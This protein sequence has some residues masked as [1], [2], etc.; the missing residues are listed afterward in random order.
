AQKFADIARRH[1]ILYGKDVLAGLDVPRTA[2]IFRLRQ[3]LLNLTLRL[4]EAYVA[5][6]RRPE[7]VARILADTLGPLRAASA[8]LLELEGV[9]KPEASESLRAVAKS[10]GPPY[11]NAAAQLFA[12][13][14]G[15]QV[16]GQPE[17]VLSQ[18]IELVTCI[19]QRAT[20]LT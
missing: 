17:A 14:R 4:R 3:I 18:V 15:E 19:S 12:A 9:A 13:H 2:E 11:E 20:R 7:Q 10:F 16:G 6:G 5:R 1:R 8:P